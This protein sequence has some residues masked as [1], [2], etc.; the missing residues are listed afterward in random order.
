MFPLVSFDIGLFAVGRWVWTQ[1]KRREFDFD[2]AKDRIRG[3]TLLID[4][5]EKYGQ[6]EP[7][8]LVIMTWDGG[9]HDDGEPHK[10]SHDVEAYF[11][12]L[13]S[14]ERTYRRYNGNIHEYDRV[15]DGDDPNID[16]EKQWTNIITIG[17]PKVN[18]I[19]EQALDD[20][21]NGY[22]FAGI[23]TVDD[24]EQTAEPIGEPD[25][26]ERRIIDKA[27]NNYFETTPPA[28]DGWED[29]A[30]V[31]RIRNP[32]DETNNSSDM[33]VVS[34]TYGPGTVAAAKFFN[35]PDLLGEVYDGD[36]EYFQAVLRVRVNS[37]GTIS[38]MEKVDDKTIH[39][40]TL[41][42]K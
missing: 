37:L 35:R 23:D 27:S 30:L 1:I 7:E 42:G 21:P 2:H 29:L 16:D 19:T 34:G 25:T 18:K 9:V 24:S 32:L 31:A 38:S 28:E 33:I 15:V 14:L 6:D 12:V 22:D 40:Q 17:G 3:K 4:F 5:W 11:E 8:P 13:D 39:E 10:I 36:H 41:G 26:D 20:C